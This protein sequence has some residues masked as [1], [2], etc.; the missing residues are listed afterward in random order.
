MLRLEYSRQTVSA[1]W[2][3]IP[4]LPGLD[5][6]KASLTL[7]PGNLTIWCSD[8]NILGKLSQS[9]VV[10]VL[11]SQRCLANSR[12]NDVKLWI[13]QFMKFIYGKTRPHPDAFYTPIVNI[14]SPHYNFT[15]PQW[16][17]P[18][19][20]RWADVNMMHWS[21]IFFRLP[22][23]WLRDAKRAWLLQGCMQWKKF[24]K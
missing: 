12:Y 23:E 7:F 16:L 2:L 18:A 11:A 17:L 13:S 4:W 1:S 14:T 10:D 9:L 24:T 15:C 5:L 6:F 3:L 21:P 19:F 22:L 20:G 8:W